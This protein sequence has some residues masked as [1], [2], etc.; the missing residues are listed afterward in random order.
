MGS[1]EPRSGA[2]VRDA[3]AG[4]RESKR[5]PEHGHVLAGGIGRGLVEVATGG[6]SAPVTFRDVRK[7]CQTQEYLVSCSRNDRVQ[8]TQWARGSVVKRRSSENLRNGRGKL[9]T[10]R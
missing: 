10:R 8:I 6:V 3:S 1:T 9:G 5:A 2:V 4:A 7:W